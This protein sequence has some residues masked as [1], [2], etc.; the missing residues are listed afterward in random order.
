MLSNQIYHK[1][2]SLWDWLVNFYPLKSF[3]KKTS[4]FIKRYKKLLLT[5]FMAFLISDLM[6]IKSYSFLIPSKELPPLKSRLP[7]LSSGLSPLAHKSI[8]ENNLF[9]TGPIP[10]FM[11]ALSNQSLEPV[12]SELPFTLKGTIIHANPKKSVA[13]VKSNKKNKSESYQI[14][15][16][17]E[18]QAE[19]RE[20]KRGK[21]I[22]FNQNLNRLEYFEFPEDQKSKLNFLSKK[23]E[24]AKKAP[25][26]AS[27][28]IK[29]LP[30]GSRSAKRSD[31]NDKLKKLPEILSEAR[32]MPHKQG[33]EIVGFRFVS[34]DK[35]SILRDLGFEKGDIIKQVN[36][37]PVTSA[38]E[39]LELFEQLK[40]E[41]GVNLLVQKQGKDV[42]LK[43]KVE[44]DA[45]VL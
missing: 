33:G 39:A 38:E 45:P 11:K 44:E 16:I 20:I 34:I 8:W 42:E 4:G 27:G 41:S 37:S 21:V 22:V 19:V 6:L 15:D 18:N 28:L 17:I 36:G 1:I 26:K 7:V 3:I 30:D 13:T 32:V 2:K 5:L 10:A 23:P 40:G 29:T 14:T 25:K 12:K 24:P 31:L 9:H 35:G 43:Y